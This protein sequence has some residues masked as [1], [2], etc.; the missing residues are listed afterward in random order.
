MRQSRPPRAAQW[1][2]RRA[3]PRDVRE[4]VAADIDELF[5]RRCQGGRAVT[6]RLWYWR[7][8]ASFWIHFRRPVSIGFSWMDFRLGLRML[9]RY[10]GLAL[11]GI[12]GMAVGV[13]I[14]AGGYSVMNAFT[15]PAL[16]LDEGDRIVAI[17]NWDL[18]RHR[19]ERRVTHDFLAW[20]AGLTSVVDIGA[21]RQVGRN[22]IVPGV[23]PE[24]LRIAEM[25]AAG[26]RVA[27]VAPLLG[28]YLLDDDE[29]AGAPAVV[30]IGAGLWRS[31][32]NADPGIVGRAI[33]LGDA[34]H[35]V[36]GVMPDEFRFPV[37]HAVWVPL[38]LN[39][40][41]HERREGPSLAVF[42]RLA[43]GATLDAARAELETV[44]QRAAAAFPTT[45]ARLRPAA[46]PYTHPFFDIDDPQTAWLARLLQYLMAVLLIVVCVNV[47]ILVYARTA[48]RGGEIAI[49]TALG[50]SRRRVVAQ[51]FV[52][53]L[54]LSISASI[55]GVALTSVGLTQVNG[56][57]QRAFDQALPFWWK[58]RVSPGTLVYVAALTVMAAAIVGAVPALKAT[59]RRVQTGLQSISAGG[60]AGMQLGSV[61]TILIV[62]QVA[63]AVALLPAAVY[64]AW[65][66]LRYGLQAP[67]FA[68]DE[69]LTA[70]LTMD[71]ATGTTVAADPTEAEYAA[72]YAGRQAELVRRLED[73]PAVVAITSMLAAPGDEPSVFVEAEGVPV[74]EK[75]G[76]YSLGD[77]TRMGYVSRFSRVDIDYFKVF[78][79]TVLTGRGFRAGDADVAAPGVIANRAFVEQVLGGGEAVG[80]RIRFVGRGGDTSADHVELNRWFEI[81]GVVADFPARRMESGLASAK[82]YQAVAPG[83]TYPL[84]LALRLRGTTPSAYSARLREISAA[85][86]P[87]L[88]L[89]A[90]AS[91]D[92]VL[93][94]EQEMMRLVAIGLGAVTASV[95]ILSAAGVYA[96]MSF[97][98]ARR[99]KEIGIRAALGA[100]PARLLRGIFSRVGLQLAA[101][102]GLGAAVAAGLEA[103]SGGEMLEGHGAFVLPIVAL[104]MTMV[105]LCAAVGPARRGLRIHPNEALREP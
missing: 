22:L 63:V 95:V 23:Q 73:D 26:F 96:L 5:R 40:S 51:L 59:G 44:G 34:I 84:T 55:V 91:L 16:P 89:R 64:H 49:R 20:R 27:R 105:G 43:P 61:W 98:V 87:N 74:P 9:V 28:R 72:R 103:L 76:D 54:V 53:A 15:S 90:V 17:Q 24:T 78:G 60:G 11:V 75:P 41:R 102:A 4:H 25:S 66:S 94:R 77:G 45:H 32:F 19:P 71:R 81:V 2:L 83:R 82:V 58:F 57:M 101:G 85:L 67:G 3:L 69:F 12:L 65:S 38:R 68:A 100:D 99:R 35:T 47:A 39:P 97:T 79:V 8:A 33:Q 1:L 13:A 30:V 21:Y 92:T 56:A 7:Q 50:A 62:A 88:Q 42:G 80:R 46:L 37:D 48:T 93:R 6:A 86:D 31:R 18:D 14:A 52:E 70:Q 10:P 36:V 104:V 29:R